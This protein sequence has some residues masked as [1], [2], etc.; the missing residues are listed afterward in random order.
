MILVSNPA[1]EI[2]DLSHVTDWLVS[3]HHIFFSSLIQ[4][5]QV[6]ST[7]RIPLIFRT[8]NRTMTPK[9]SSRHKYCTVKICYKENGFNKILPTKNKHFS[10]LIKET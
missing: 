5:Y 4:S 10:P 2:E 1:G 3:G 8:T 9:L 7:K 6:L